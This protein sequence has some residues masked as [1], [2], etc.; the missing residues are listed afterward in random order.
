ME[1]PSVRQVTDSRVLAALAH[2]L[3]RRL[4]DVLKVYGPPARPRC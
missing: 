4:M 2:P 3:R 1:R